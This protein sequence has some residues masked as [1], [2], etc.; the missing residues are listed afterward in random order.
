MKSE[1]F[2]V[3]KLLFP[4]TIAAIAITLAACKPYGSGQTSQT[5]SITQ[6]NTTA[7]TTTTEGGT[8]ISATGSGFEPAS[9]IVSA[10]SP[11]TWKNS[12]SGTVQVGSD[13]HPT[14]RL[15]QEITSGAFTLDLEVGE[16]KT[17]TVTKT[18]TWG[19]HD[20]LK[21]TVAGTVVVN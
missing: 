1:K 17:V 15:N 2:R 3:K 12:S 7:E 16:S 4:L 20:H 9:V 14:H 8:I 6:E 10:G 19:Y 13:N 11:I 5:S 18:G 21:P